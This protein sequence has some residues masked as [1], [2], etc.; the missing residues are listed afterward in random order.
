VPCCFA[1]DGDVIYT[2]VDDVKLKRGRQLLRLENVAR[3][4]DVCLLVDEYA[5]QWS[6]LWWVRVDGRAHVA[7]PGSPEHAAAVDLLTRKYHQYRA[8][9]PRG[10][11]IAIDVVRWR[12]WP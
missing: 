6:R 2:A 7:H 8:A 11:A 12:G 5:E 4:A 10:P 9:P 1:V 3:H